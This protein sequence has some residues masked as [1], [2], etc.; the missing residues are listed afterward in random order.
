MMKRNSEENALDAGGL[1]LEYNLEITIC[2]R[3][4]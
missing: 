1:E 4:P 3:I 2:A